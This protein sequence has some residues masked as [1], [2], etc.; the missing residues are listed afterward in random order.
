[1][2][3]LDAKIMKPLPNNGQDVETGAKCVPIRS[4]ILLSFFRTAQTRELI[5]FALLLP[6]KKASRSEG[7]RHSSGFNNEFVHAIVVYV[8]RPP[9]SIFVES[10][11]AV[12]IH[13][14]LL[15]LTT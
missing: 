13:R 12:F 3:D 14:F 10:V 9:L 1:M 15:G 6:D 11:E 8:A 7:S 4:T 5:P 2:I